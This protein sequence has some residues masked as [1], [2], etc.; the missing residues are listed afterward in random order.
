MAIP[1]PEMTSVVPIDCPWKV[2]DRVKFQNDYGVEF[3]PY[4]VQGFTLPGAE[5]KK[6]TKI[7]NI[8]LD[9][10]CYWF[11]TDKESLTAWDEELH[12]H[13]IKG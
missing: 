1:I 10:S 6:G 9:Y 3:G 13:L 8:Y 11:P 12:G 4:I 5:L 7:S 2:G